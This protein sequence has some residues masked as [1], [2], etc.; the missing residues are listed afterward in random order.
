MG[1]SV[2]VQNAQTFQEAA[3]APD[4]NRSILRYS[5]GAHEGLFVSDTMGG[6]VV[7]GWRITDI[8]LRNGEG[9]A[10]PNS[11]GGGWVRSDVH[12]LLNHTTG[13]RNETIGS[14][15][16]VIFR[17]PHGWI[18]LSSIT[19]TKLNET[20]ALANELFGATNV[21]FLSL[22]FVNNVMTM[23]DLQELHRTNVMLKEFARKNHS[24]VN[25]IMVL[26]FG[27][28]GDGLTRWNAQ[29]LGYNVTANDTDYLFERLE[30]CPRKGFRRAIAQVCTERVKDGSK[31][32]G[33]GNSFSIDGLHWCSETLNG[34]LNAGTAC[35]I[36]CL[37]S[38]GVVNVHDCERDCND[39]FMSLRSVGPF[40]DDFAAESVE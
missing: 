20:V 5:W 1:D 11:G 27:R 29:L 13:S 32:C 39:R 33:P 26:D 7:A 34:R 8:L 23:D 2:A 15:D 38:D 28:L 12:N 40:A 36:E 30:C 16:V 25:N 21:V 22:P 17:I 18:Q 14:F 6:G 10:L 31:N 3:R 35:L 9:K 37:Y 24:L 19:E 4:C